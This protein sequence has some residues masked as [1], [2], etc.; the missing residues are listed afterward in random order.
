MPFL[1]PASL[2]WFDPKGAYGRALASELCPAAFPAIAS[3]ATTM[4]VAHA[5]ASETAVR[6]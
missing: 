3:T 6:S 2:A 4:T 1:L 5:D